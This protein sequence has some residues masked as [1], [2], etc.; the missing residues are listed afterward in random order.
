[1]SKLPQTQ[2]FNAVPFGCEVGQLELK[3]QGNNM[4]KYA[5]DARSSAKNVAGTTA[6]P[7][8]SFGI[9]DAPAKGAILRR[10]PCALF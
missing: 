7:G 5:S 8:S 6:F 1:M 10:T 2:L 4:V 3:H 9:R